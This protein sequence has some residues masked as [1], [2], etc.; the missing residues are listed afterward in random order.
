M[1]CDWFCCYILYFPSKFCLLFFE[2]SSGGDHQNG[3]NLNGNGAI[4]DDQG[5]HI[6]IENEDDSYKDEVEVNL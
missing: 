4:N 5:H 2:A 3:N 6:S 1:C